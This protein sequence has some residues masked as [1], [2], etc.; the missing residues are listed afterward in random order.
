MP[1]QK[2]WILEEV[3]VI[4]ILRGDKRETSEL[5][6]KN[7]SVVKTESDMKE[8]FGDNWQEKMLVARTFY[9]EFSDDSDRCLCL[10]SVGQIKKALNQIGY[11]ILMHNEHRK[12]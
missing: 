8:E 5:L 4:Y 9:A 12:L 1:E 7:G 3:N 6:V 11:V 2:F 10:E